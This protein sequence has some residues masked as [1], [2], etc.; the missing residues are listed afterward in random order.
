MQVIKDSFWLEENEKRNINKLEKDI[1]IDIAIIGGGITGLTTALL[2][3][4]YGMEVAVFEGYEIGYG[5]TGHTTA[6]VTSQHGIIYSEL[7]KCYNDGTAKK[8][9]DANENAIKNIKRI[10]DKYHID[11]D[12]QTVK[13]NLYASDKDN[14]DKLFKEY[15]AAKSVG[16][17]ASC[18]S[19]ISLPFKT[20]ASLTLSDQGM[21]HPKKYAD[22]IANALKKHKVKIYEHTRIIKIDEGNTYVLNTDCSIK[23]EADTVVIATKY[24][25]INKKGMFFTKLHVERSYVVAASLPNFN[26]DGYYINV[27]KN[28]RSIRPYSLGKESLILIA[29]ANHEA[30]ECNDTEKPYADLIKFAEE[31]DPDAKIKY[32]WSTQD[33]ITLDKIPYI[34][35]L[36][37]DMPN[38]YLATGFNKWG[39]THSMVAGIIISDDIMNKKNPYSDI[40]DPTRSL[41]LVAAKELIVQGADVA[42]DYL[43]II[44]PE[45]TKDIDKIVRGEGEIIN[46]NG[47][48]VGVFKD[49]NNNVFMVNPKCSHMG[50]LLSFNKAERSWDCPC[51]GSRFSYLGE[52]IDSPA[53]KTIQMIKG[54]E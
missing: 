20:H 46:I 7:V 37:K 13:S 19:N 6:K 41:N 52:I 17:P 43:K 40:Y 5:A 36:S 34:G 1:K 47:D 51:H 28:V 42:A 44:K 8:Y 27:E 54:K 30:G 29:G 23:I 22:G 35:K 18:T 33:C 10:I 3:S 48:S 50:C 26:L 16:L 24:P 38:V 9:A 31:I 4:E 53:V 21:M 15:S 45:K 11:C 2:L 12:Y 25:I 49:E 39:M 14:V 32:R